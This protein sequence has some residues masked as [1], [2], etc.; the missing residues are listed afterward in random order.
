VQKATVAGELKTE[1]TQGVEEGNVQLS[2]SHPAFPP[3]SQ[4]QMSNQV[5]KFE[6]SNAI[7]LAGNYTVAP[8]KED[9]PLNG[10]TT[11]DLALISKHVLGIETLGTPYKMIAADANKSGTI[12]TFDVVELRKLILGIYDELPNNKSWRFVDKSYAFPNP[13][14]PSP[15][16]SPKAK[17][18]RTSWPA[19]WAKTSWA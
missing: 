15:P 9:N 12:T 14:N 13:S 2:G 4:Y 16:L 18:F 7:P 10:V 8:V 17:R 1:S 3:V 5:G 6:F 19:R 11:L